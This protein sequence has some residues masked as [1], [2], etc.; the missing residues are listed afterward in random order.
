MVLR[1]STGFLVHKSVKL[2]RKKVDTCLRRFDITVTQWGALRTLVEDGELSQAEISARLAMDRATCG[3][4]LDKLIAKGLIEKKLSGND[5]RSYCVKAL[6]PGVALI[7][8][9]GPEIEQ[10][11]LLMLKGIS[12]DEMKTLERM[13]NIMISNLSQEE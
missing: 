1:K 13:M 3:T 9:S 4:V 5:R 8:A 10:I 11:S 7:E 2:L 12:E 6:P